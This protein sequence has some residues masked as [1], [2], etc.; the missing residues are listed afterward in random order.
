MSASCFSLLWEAYRSVHPA[1][2]LDL[3][4]FY[5]QGSTGSYTPSDRVTSLVAL[6]SL[7]PFIIYFSPLSPATLSSAHIKILKPSGGIILP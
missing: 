3:G 6:F 5:T 7:G 2:Q 1:P 4:N